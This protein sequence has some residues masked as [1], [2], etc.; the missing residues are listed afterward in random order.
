MKTLLSDKLRLR[1]SNVN[2]L[3]FIAAIAVIICHSYAITSNRED[4]VSVYTNGQ[5]NLGGIAV[6]V[7]FVLSGLYVAKSLSKEHSTRTFL[8]KRCK[9]IFPQLWIVVILSVLIL[10]PFFT[11]LQLSLYFC[12]FETWKYLLNLV[13][14]PVHNLPGVFGKNAYQTINGPLWTMPI[15]FACYVFL[16]INAFIAEK[17]KN[18]TI[19]NR[20]NL[21]I[22]SIIAFELLFLASIYLNNSMMISVFRPVVCFWVGV[23]MFDYSDRVVLSPLIGTAGMAILILAARISPIFNI[24]LP[25]LFSYS[26]IAIVLGLP[27]IKW[28]WKM[29][30]LSYEMYLLG[31]PT[32]QILVAVIGTMSPFMN[33]LIAVPLA[34][35]E[36]LLLSN[37]TKFIFKG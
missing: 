17:S 16:A 18:H 9:R 3:R 28:N 1:S 12:S 20:I 27:Q 11:N 32:Q 34:I 31:W 14:L 33:W 26:I 37:I 25:L 8:W 13:L 24:L 21:D 35:V 10:G 29:F 15:E 4:L 36:G 7:F 2:L 30:E 23:L 22:L 5:C 19:H 6:A